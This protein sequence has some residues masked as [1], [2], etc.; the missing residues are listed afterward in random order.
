[1]E[2][3]EEEE[4]EES[5]WRRTKTRKKLIFFPILVSD[6]SSFKAWNDPVFING[7]R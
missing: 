4:E 5:W 6:F 7:G 2:E 1:M 3:E